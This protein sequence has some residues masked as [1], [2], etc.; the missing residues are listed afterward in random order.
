MPVSP[1]AERTGFKPQ[2]Y[3]ET[4]A[5]DS[6]QIVA[7]KPKDAPEPSL[8]LEVGQLRRPVPMANGDAAPAKERSGL[9]AE[10]GWQWQLKVA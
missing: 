1:W 10:E 4:N 2:L 7:T 9:E 6:G 5:S 3:C 8:D